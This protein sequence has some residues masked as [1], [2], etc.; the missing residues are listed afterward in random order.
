MQTISVIRIIIGG[1]LGTG[2][3]C[4]ANFLLR[5]LFLKEYD[6]N[7]ED[8]LCKQVVIDGKPYNLEI[9]DTVD[10]EFRNGE[11]KIQILLRNDVLIYTY[12]IDDVTSFDNLYHRYAA[13][14]IHEESDHKKLVYVNGKLL[15]VPPII[16]VGT[17]KDLENERQVA[18]HSA[19]KMKAEL[20][21][22]ECLECSSLNNINIEE[23]LKLTIKYALEYQQSEKDLTHLY[24]DDESNEPKHSS[25][26]SSLNS[27]LSTQQK[28]QVYNNIGSKFP[29][30]KE[31]ISDTAIK[32]SSSVL[33]MKKDN[34]AV[35]SN[36]VTTKTRMH[37]ATS[38]KNSGSIK[39]C[40]TIM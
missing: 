23:L 25:A 3:T 2:K 29:S 19:E 26:N 28:P 33:D 9:L 12:A 10:N 11:E 8:T 21:F 32:K 13:L 27:H 35:K 1:D 31:D 17:K 24:A 34:V 40:C 38:K 22:Q 39:A 16:L 18:V 36:K 14:P 4:L 37:T 5:S 20:N 7:I 15:R 6:A 30:I